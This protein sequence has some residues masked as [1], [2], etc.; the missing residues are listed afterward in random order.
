MGFEL[1]DVSY[2]YG[3]YPAVD[4]VSLSLAPG[5]F[6]GVI[7]PNGCGKTTLLDLLCGHKRPDG[8]DIRYNDH[9]LPDYGKRHLAQ[10]MALVPQEYR[11]NFPYTAREV[12][13]MGRYPHIGR[14]SAPSV[15]DMAFVDAVLADCRA[16]HLAGRYMTELSGGEKQRVIFARAMAQ[17]TP[18]LLLDEPCANLDVKHALRLL[19]LAAGRVARD[20]A[21]VVAVM[22]DINLAARFADGLV[23]MKSGQVT[24]SG[25]TG[26]IFDA[27]ILRE[28][29]EVD[30]RLTHEAAINAP[31]VVFLR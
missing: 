1:E 2:A 22:H 26:D 11:V 25:P 4:G 16:D 3:A 18:V 7:G 17:Q 10:Q 13:A 8:G 20:G 6:Y 24:A 12:V 21:T 31:Q 28:V 23:F 9:R 29:F 19:D 15:D 14:F 5:R 30:V 27:C